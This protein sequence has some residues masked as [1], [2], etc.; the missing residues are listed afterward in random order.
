MSAA[1]IP[2]ALLTGFLGAG[3]TTLVNRVLSGSHG[4]RIGVIVNEFGNVGIDGALITGAAG[5][6]VELANG[7]ICCAT[8]G[9]LARAVH[10]VIAAGDALDGILIETSGLADPLSVIDD[11][12]TYRFAR[13]AR[14]EGVVTVID[15]ENFDRN[16][17][18]AEA[19]Y[20]QIT[21]ADLLLINKVDLVAPEIPGLIEAGL[22]QLNPAAPAVRC[23]GCD[24]PLE[25]L[26]SDMRP[27]SPASAAGPAHVHHHAHQR[28]ESA[29]LQVSEPLS[30][31]R[32][33]AWL[34][35]LPASVYRA[36][37]FVR[38]AGARALMLVHA[39]GARH[40]LEPAPPK[41]ETTGATLVV[42]GQDLPAAE[43]QAGLARCA[44]NVPH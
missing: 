8:R 43:L 35:G 20:A 6:L 31:E 36:K 10:E 13:A 42:I 1:A 12:D 37:G 4:R 40:N 29:A 32:F 9:D 21:C 41:A 7:C 30:Q 27:G 19:A 26:L 15:A 22:R 25:L 24:V 17:E 33:L 34:D 16:L 14:L 2:I 44:A 11:L 3:K 39:V 38:F 18:R 23:V 28:F 5:P